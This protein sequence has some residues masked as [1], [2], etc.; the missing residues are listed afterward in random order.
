MEGYIAKSD[1]MK[2]LAADALSVSSPPRPP[3][4]NPRKRTTY[5]EDSEGN[6]DY[7]SNQKLSRSKV[8]KGDHSFAMSFKGAVF[9]GPV[10]IVADANEEGERSC[11]VEADEDDIDDSL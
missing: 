8:T 5:E 7:Q 9:N 11:K 4:F 3:P 6:D 2:H 1:P 10:K